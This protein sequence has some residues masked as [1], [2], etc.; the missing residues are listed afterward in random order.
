MP[1][2][3]NGA[4]PD[5]LSPATTP[6][7]RLTVD[8]PQDSA[9]HPLYVLLSHL[10]GR[11]VE[12]GCEDCD[13]Y[14]VTIHMRKRGPSEK[15]E[16]FRER[17]AEVEAKPLRDALTEW[18][19]GVEVK[20]ADVRPAVPDGVVDRPAEVWEALLAIADEAGGEWPE[21]AREACRYFVLNAEPGKMTLGVRL[22][23]DIRAIFKATVNRDRMPTHDLIVALHGLDEA[24]W[25]DLW[26]KPL[27]TRKL[28]QE[29]ERYGVR[30]IQWKH[31][32]VRHRGYVTWATEQ[33]INQAG[34]ADA[35][36]RYL[37]SPGTS[38]TPGTS[39]VSPD[40]D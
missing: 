24:P 23:H 14:Q 3:A 30:P 10:A 25:G 28:G 27:T 19:G 40:P 8:S 31:E 39:Q 33:P 11:R 7:G 16:P 36:A 38:G 5:P 4:E 17:D 34:L 21:K 18:V 15:V 1:E 32:G 22:L 35:W 20:L 12:G 2:N 9:A 37:V 26:G 29:L 13:A 6:V